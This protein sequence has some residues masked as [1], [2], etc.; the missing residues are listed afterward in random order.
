MFAF[1]DAADNFDLNFPPP[2][3]K[4][5]GFQKQ[6]DKFNAEVAKLEKQI[7]EAVGTPEETNGGL[8]K[9]TNTLTRKMRG[10]PKSP[11]GW[12]MVMKQREKPR[13]T[14]IHKRG[15]FLDQGD[16]VSAG[17]PAVF[18]PLPKTEKPTRLDFAR[19]LVDPNN[20]L[21]ARV[22]VNRIWQRYFGTGLIETE[23][24]FGMQGDPP[25]HPKL[26]DWIA[27]EFMTRSWSVKAVHKLIVSS[28][29]YRQSSAYRP[30]IAKTDP[31]NRL[32]ARQARLRLE[33]EI[34]RDTALA[35]SGLL[36]RPIGGK[37]VYPPQPEGVYAFTQV[38]KKWK[39]DAGPNRYRRGMYAY[40]W[41]SQPFPALMTFDFPESNVTCTRR[42]RSNTPLQALTLA[43][44]VSFLETS[45]A[46][47]K[48]ILAEASPDDEARIRYAFR[49]CVAREPSSLERRR[50]ESLIW[51][52]R[53]AFR[54]DKPAAAALL[55]T[56]KD[57]TDETV[58]LAA[59][60][61]F[62]RVLMNLDE[63]ITRE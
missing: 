53:E 37:G 11:A 30:D 14:R 34:I 46:M 25:S 36:T 12:A 47:A 60:T 63:F 29:T 18:H 45:R 19:W 5:A 55:G 42:V 50:L 44:D 17:T 2:K 8:K 57:A 16:E 7:T 39:A 59:W 54:A 31:A 28:A 48:R 4:A 49:L 15:N 22:T 51:Q 35:T 23:N 1:F 13:T 33:A 43:N 27:T 21:S 61:T 58:E 26:I 62:S 41:R 6:L 52:Q 3:D 56:K 20:P 24:D 40:F 32:L 9:L 38:N 10:K